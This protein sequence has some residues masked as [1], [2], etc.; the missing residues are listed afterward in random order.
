MIGPCSVAPASALSHRVWSVYRPYL[1]AAYLN[2]GYHFFAP[3]P[4]PS[5]LVRYEVELADGSRQSGFFPDRTRHRPRLLYHRYFMLSEHLNALMDSGAAPEV[6]GA[7]VASF[8]RRILHVHRGQRAT[9]YLMR[10]LLPEPAAVLAGKP[11]DEPSLYRERLLGTF[12]AGG[13]VEQTS[14]AATAAVR[15]GASPERPV[16]QGVQ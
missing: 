8:A 3:E 2:H 11:L 13:M 15:R 1:Q 5:H 6:V 7:Y 10:H 14:Q 16:S 12:D 9:L 4:G